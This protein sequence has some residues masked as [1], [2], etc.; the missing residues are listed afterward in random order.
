MLLL[1]LKNGF[2]IVIRKN[3]LLPEMLILSELEFPI[4]FATFS[5]EKGCLELKLALRHED[6]IFIV[7]IPRRYVSIKSKTW[8]W[9]NNPDDEILFIEAT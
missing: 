2:N 9:T 5:I 8:S 7:N 6:R 1:W 4:P 3:G